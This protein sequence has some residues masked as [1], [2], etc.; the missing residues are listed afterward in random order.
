MILLRYLDVLKHYFYAWI[1]PINVFPCS[2]NPENVNRDPIWLL[3]TC[4]WTTEIVGLN[5]FH[6]LLPDRNRFDPTYLFRQDFRAIWEEHII[7]RLVIDLS[8]SLS[9][10]LS[11]SLSLVQPNSS[12]FPNC[13]LLLGPKLYKT[14]CILIWLHVYWT[15]VNWHNFWHYTN[16]YS[17]LSPIGRPLAVIFY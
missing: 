7:V 5:F 12:P 8:F 14:L 17:I 10:F 15:I 6:S 11:L 9:F 3:F 1:D 16:W 4:T 2:D 13:Q